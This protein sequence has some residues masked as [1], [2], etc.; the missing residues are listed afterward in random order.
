ML[1]DV[2]AHLL[3]GTEKSDKEMLEITRKRYGTDRVIISSLIS[4]DT[5]PE[6]VTYLNDQTL[7]Y[8]KERPDYVSGLCYLNPRNDNSVEELDRCLDAGMIGVK[9]WV[10]TYCDDPLVNPIAERCIERN[11]PILIHTFYK[12]VGQYPRE[13]HAEHVANLARRY[14]DLTLIMAHLGAH[15][16]RELPAIKNTPN[17][18]VDFSGSICH[19]DD[20]PYALSVL[21]SGRIMFAT[22]G[23]IGFHPSYGMLQDADLTLQEYENIA[24]RNAD[25]V[26]FGGRYAEKV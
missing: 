16:F 14:P 2:H 9:L 19:A 8:M 26:F 25:K 24:W 12:S 11:V 13:N 10:A 22:D 21:G 1:I 3:R 4:C 17:V 23:P 15:A 5:D 20:L 18:Y 7:Q 6:E